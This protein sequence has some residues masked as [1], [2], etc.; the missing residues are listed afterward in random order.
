MNEVA[1]Y[2][3]HRTLYA[4]GP[5]RKGMGSNSFVLCSLVYLVRSSD[6][7]FAVAVGEVIATCR[8][9]AIARSSGT[10]T[11]EAMMTVKCFGPSMGCFL[12]RHL[13]SYNLQPNME[14]ISRLLHRQR[15]LRYVAASC[16]RGLQ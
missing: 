1:Q 6:V 12:R 15:G 7:L 14:S 3:I 11:R 2:T 13:P 10:L 5:Q 9:L 8:D 4:M 16:V